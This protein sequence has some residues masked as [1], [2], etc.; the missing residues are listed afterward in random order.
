[1]ERIVR[2]RETMV[3][4]AE[5]GPPSTPFRT[6]RGSILCKQFWLAS[7]E[8]PVS[9]R[10]GSGSVWLHIVNFKCLKYRYIAGTRIIQ[11]LAR[12]Y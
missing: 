12:F 2:W 9:L 8:R 1:M 7:P 10:L 6:L 11:W 3:V 4:C 5:E